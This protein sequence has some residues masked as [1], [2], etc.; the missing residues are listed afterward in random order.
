MVCA[1]TLEVV[2]EDRAGLCRLQGFD[3]GGA[4]L[5]GSQERNF[6]KKFTWA[7]DRQDRRVPN[8]RAD[9][10]REAPGH[11]QMDRVRRVI[12]VEDDLPAG[13]RASPCDRQN[14]LHFGIWDAVE[15]G[16]THPVNLPRASAIGRCAPR[17]F[18]LTLAHCVKKA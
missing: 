9:P 14:S 5:F 2:S 1:Q 10:H 3:G 7:E 4:S 18:T 12:V 8:G 11:D 17:G 15:D 16:P 13:E 6:S